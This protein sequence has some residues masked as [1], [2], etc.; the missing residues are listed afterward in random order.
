MCKIKQMLRFTV[1]NKY[2]HNTD[3][4]SH[5]V[6]EFRNSLHPLAVLRHLLNFTAANCIQLSVKYHLNVAK[7]VVD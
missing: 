6:A 1:L 2:F 5:S 4:N 7:F 3:D